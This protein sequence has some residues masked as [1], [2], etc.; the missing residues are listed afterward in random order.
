M[1]DTPLL[2]WTPAERR[3]PDAPGFKAAG[4]SE[5]AASAISGRAAT[6]RGECLR[7]LKR[8]S[9][10]ADE[11]AELMHESVLAIRPRFSELRVAGDIIDSGERRRNSSG[12]RAVVWTLAPR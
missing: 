12:R 6:L 8:R 10:T 1:T 2:D 3:Y 5:E 11:A 4:T 7:L 9:M